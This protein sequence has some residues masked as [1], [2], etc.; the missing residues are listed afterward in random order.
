[1]K[2]SMEEKEMERS[3]SRGPRNSS[4]FRRNDGPRNNP[5]FRRNSGQRRNSGFRRNDG[6][7]EMHDAICSKCNKECKVPFKPTQGKPVYCSDC[8]VKPKRF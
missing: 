8:F 3:N 1:M 4:G 5:G 6:P 7:R 2:A